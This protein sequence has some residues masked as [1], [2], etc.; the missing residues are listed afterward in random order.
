MKENIKFKTN[1]N[2]IK[3]HNLFIITFY[4]FFFFECKKNFYRDYWS[5]ML[6]IKLLFYVKSNDKLTRLEKLLRLLKHWF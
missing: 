6:F 3:A 4:Y 1:T 2:I 5:F